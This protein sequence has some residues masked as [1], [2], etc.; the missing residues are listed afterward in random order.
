MPIGTELLLCG[1]VTPASTAASRAGA[2]DAGA[3]GRLLPPAANVL[4]SLREVIV[5]PG[6]TSVVPS[7]LREMSDGDEAPTGASSHDRREHHAGFSMLS[8]YH[9]LRTTLTLE[10]PG[11]ERPPP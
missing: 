7:A 9:A 5:A 6:L 2:G 11:P 10:T 1:G 3:G 8:C 4:I